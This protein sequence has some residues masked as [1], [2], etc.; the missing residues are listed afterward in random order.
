MRSAGTAGRRSHRQCTAG[1]FRALRSNDLLRKIVEVDPELLLTYLLQLLVLALVV[2]ADFA[3]WFGIPTDDGLNIVLEFSAR[4]GDKQLKGID[5]VRFNGAG[6]LSSIGDNLYRASE[7]SGDPI[8][9]RP[10]E[11]GAAHR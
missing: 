4:V 1:A 2:V 11:Q 5:L 10:G 3:D 7:A 8:P 9:V 6:L